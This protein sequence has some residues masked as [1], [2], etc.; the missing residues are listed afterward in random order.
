MKHEA[1]YSYSSSHAGIHAW[2][3][4]LIPEGACPWKPAHLSA[5]PKRVW[6]CP[7]ECWTQ[8][9][10]CKSPTCFM[11]GIK[12]WIHRKG[13][14]EVLLFG[15]TCSENMP[16][17]KEVFEIYSAALLQFKKTLSKLHIQPGFCSFC[18]YLING[19]NNLLQ[20]FDYFWNIPANANLPTPHLKSSDFKKSFHKS[21][22]SLQPNWSSQYSWSTGREANKVTL[23]SLPTEVS[24]FTLQEQQRSHFLITH[25]H[26]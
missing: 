14:S 6:K 5:L 1:Q 25:S 21:Q 20:L 3:S 16:K 17:I 9:L 10:R 12:G 18:E 26:H 13:A 22:L 15:A 24:L 4:L 19:Y 11:G 7:Q 2:Q 23:F 8:F